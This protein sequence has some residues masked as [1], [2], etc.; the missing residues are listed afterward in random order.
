MFSKHR[1]EALSDG[2]FAIAMTLLILDLKVPLDTQPGHLGAALLHDVASWVSFIVTFGLAAQAWSLQHRVFDR[3]EKMTGGGLAL[4]FIFL[5]FVSVLPFITS[6]W[7][8][9]IR[10]PFAFVLYFSIQFALALMLML[11]LELARWKGYLK[12]GPETDQLRLRLFGMCLIMAV[13]T[14]TVGY[15]PR[16]YQWLPL[17]AMGI[18]VRAMRV[19]KNRQMK[20]A[21][22]AVQPES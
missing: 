9:H 12:L 2:V 10:E 17:L 21:S 6:V 22:L 5:F 16:Q 4:T 14:P 18:A 1:I 7:G 8:H 3:M 19:W 20:Q 15:L 13:G 11:K